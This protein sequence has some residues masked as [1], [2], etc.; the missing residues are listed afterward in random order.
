MPWH[1]PVASSIVA[2]TTRKPCVL[3]AAANSSAESV[4]ERSPARFSSETLWRPLCGHVERLGNL[5]DSHNSRRTDARHRLI[6]RP[7]EPPLGLGE[8][9]ASPV[10]AAIANAVFDATG[11][12]LRRVP[13]TPERVKEALEGGPPRAGWSGRSSEH[14]VRCSCFPF[15]GSTCAYSSSVRADI[16]SDRGCNSPGFCPSTPLL[17]SRW[18]PSHCA[19]GR[20]SPSAGLGRPEARGFVPRLQSLNRRWMTKRYRSG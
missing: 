18:A 4:T 12:R 6:D 17:E 14:W 9:S 20:S 8:A 10:A 7:S 13:F 19:S 2:R 5:S 3:S 15:S 16:S 11:V 1:W